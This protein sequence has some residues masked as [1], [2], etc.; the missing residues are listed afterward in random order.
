MAIK[1]DRSKINIDDDSTYVGLEL[2]LLKSNGKEGYFQSTPTTIEAVKEN[3]RLLLNTSKGE[4]VMQPSLG[5]SL[6]NYLFENFDDELKVIISEEIESTFKYWL[7]F[8]TITNL[9]I[10]ND[11]TSNKNMININ[12]EFF[13]QQNFDMK[14]SIQLSIE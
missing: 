9:E 13:I 4:R 2:P 8:V 3:I 10:D 14:E 11:K 12:I 1:I 5:I 6:K 7:P